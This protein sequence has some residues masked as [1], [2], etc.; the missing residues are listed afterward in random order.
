ML[1][2]L[3]GDS[4]FQLPAEIEVPQAR[5][6]FLDEDPLIKVQL[7]KLLNK[8]ESNQKVYASYWRGQTFLVTNGSWLDYHLLGMSIITIIVIVVMFPYQQARLRQLQVIVFAMQTTQTRPTAALDFLVLRTTAP[9]SVQPVIS[10]VDVMIDFTNE[11]WLMLLAFALGLVAVYK[12]IRLGIQY[13]LHRVSTNV[14][15]SFL[16][17]QVFNGERS[18][19]MRIKAIDGVHTKIGM[20]PESSLWD[21]YY[22]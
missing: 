7:D 6:E 5:V 22:R 2:G 10:Q 12:A 21:G 13:C 17:F 11:Y 3:N 4:S 20:R 9:P 19:Y 16:I 8:T 18:V 1:T 14:T 15:Q